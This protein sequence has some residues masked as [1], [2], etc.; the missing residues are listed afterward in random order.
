MCRNAFFIAIVMLAATARGDPG[1]TMVWTATS[2]GG[3]P[4]ADAISADVGDTLTLQVFVVPDANGIVGAG[5]SFGWDP[6]ALDVTAFAE[7][8]AATSTPPG[9]N[10][11]PGTCNDSNGTFYIPLGTSMSLDAVAGTLSSVDA[12]LLTGV[13]GTGTVEPAAIEF[14]VIAE[15]DSTVD[16]VYVDGLNGVLDGNLELF[17]PGGSATVMPEPSG[18]LTI[19]SGVLM[20]LWLR[21]AQASEA[22]F[23]MG[24]ASLLVALP[25]AALAAPDTDGD[26]VPDVLDNCVLLANAPPLDCD[27]DSDGYGNACD[28]DY[29]D[30][31][32]Q[33]EVDEIQF[34]S[35]NYGTSPASLEADHDCDGTV[36]MPDLATYLDFLGL[37]T[38]PSG[39]SCAG[40]PPC[41]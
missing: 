37:P 27:T 1:I 4:G 36:G 18:G 21:R 38:G 23:P 10:F 29:D 26:G 40:F 3:T 35:T 6:T 12:G 7:C 15:A 25:L 16:V 33:A 34:F 14:E 17:F 32:I 5:L 41:P 39:L 31:G 8:P 2:G 19:L 30:D 11:V 22:R 20:I 13:I 24:V 28:A 9:G